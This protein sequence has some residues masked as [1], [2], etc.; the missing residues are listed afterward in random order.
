MVTALSFAAVAILLYS[1]SLRAGFV[2]DDWDFL[3]LVDEAGS[4]GIAFEPL[5]G[6]FFRPWVVLVYYVNYQVSVRGRCLS[7]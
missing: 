1:G 3:K 5:V 6:R 4:A 2:A 7:T